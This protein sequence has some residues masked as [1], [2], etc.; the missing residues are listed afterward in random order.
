MPLLKL[1]SNPNQG[2]GINLMLINL[3]YRAF[4]KM[5]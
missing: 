2:K 3:N 4:M 5:R 1:S